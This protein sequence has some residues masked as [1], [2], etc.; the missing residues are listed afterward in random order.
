MQRTVGG[1]DTD[2]GGSGSDLVGGHHGAI[3]HTHATNQRAGDG[4][5]GDVCLERLQHII[6][7]L[8]VEAGTLGIE[9]VDTTER[10]VGEI[11]VRPEEE[12]AVLEGIAGSD[13]SRSRYLDR[14]IGGCLAKGYPSR[15][16]VGGQQLG[17]TGGEIDPFPV[18]DRDLFPTL[19]NGLL[20]GVAGGGIKD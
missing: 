8:K 2:S 13:R 20:S 1:P 15:G 17:A 18:K 11:R 16:C 6:R 7:L 4:I 9:H 3:A 10:K 19:G 14:R 5:G 12:H